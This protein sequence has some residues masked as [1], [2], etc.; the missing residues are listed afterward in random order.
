MAGHKMFAL[1]A[2]SLTRRGYV[3]LRSDDRGT[4]ISTGEYDSATTADF[5]DDALA[6]ANYLRGRKDLGLKKIGLL[7][8][9]EGGMAAA[10]AAAKDPGIAFVISLSSPGEP[11]LEALLRQNRRLVADAPIPAVNKMRFDSVN[12]LLFHIVYANAGRPDLEQR[13]RSAYAQWKVWDDSIVKANKLEYGGHFF[14]PFETYVRQA[15]G[16]WYQYFITYDPATVLPKVHVPYLAI[17][18]DKDRISDG[19]INLA[20]I[21]AGLAAGGNRHVTVW[22][23]PG[24][25]HLYQ[26]CH[27]CDLSEYAGLPETMAPEVITRIGDWLSF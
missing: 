14:Y 4:G 2:D 8:H 7:G 16:R 19:P 18:G 6:A 27:T 3:V 17:N 21:S 22:L 24:L 20:G 23:A 25:N 12:N 10:L 11:G 13:L 1:L 9:S 15:L 26:H 5:A